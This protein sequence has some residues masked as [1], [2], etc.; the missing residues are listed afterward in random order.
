MANLTG[1][2]KTMFE[3]QVSVIPPVSKNGTPN[4]IGP[5]GSKVSHR[6]GE[7]I[8][9]INRFYYP[10]ESLETICCRAFLKIL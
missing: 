2:M 4:N 8:Y 5:K 7:L 6:I 9:K 1:E 3:Q 10:P